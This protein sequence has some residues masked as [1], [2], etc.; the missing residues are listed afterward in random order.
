MR[1]RLQNAL[2]ATVDE[3]RVNGHPEQ[4]LPNTLNISFRHVQAN[5]LLTEIADR[6]AASAG[7]ACHSDQVTLSATLQAIHIPLDYAMGTLR[8]SVGK[9]TTESEIDEAA[10]VIAEAVRHLRAGN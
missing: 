8:L 6:V 7:A 9:M 2:V 1:D 3:V 10:S 5:T 4:R